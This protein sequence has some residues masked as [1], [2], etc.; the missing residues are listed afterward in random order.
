M[1]R[2]AGVLGFVVA[3][4]GCAGGDDD[5][6]GD[7]TPILDAVP[8]VPGVEIGNVDASKVED[9]VATD[10][11]TASDAPSADTA[12]V[13]ASALDAYAADTYAADTF[14][15]DTAKA[16]TYVADTYVADTYVADTAKA[17]TYVADTYVADTY[18]ADTFVADT[19]K[20]DTFVPDTYV[21]PW[22]HTISID[23]TNDF[24]AASE[25][26]ATTTSSF[27][28]YVTWDA[29]A[30]YVAYNGS[31]VASG[32][33][34]RWLFVYLDTDPGA[35]TGATSSEQYAT[36]RHSFASGFGAEHYYAWRADG[37]FPQQ[38]KYG[39]GAWTSVAG[40]VTAG[41]SGTYVEVKIPWA[42]V[43]SPAK[44][45]VSSFFLNE[46][47]GGEWTYAGLYPSAFTDGYSGAAAPK[48][49]GSYLKVDLASPAAP[50]DPANK[51]P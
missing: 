5:V 1:R 27:D 25:K 45:G 39:A 30:L 34:T 23:G 3:L 29:T 40:T 16:D 7:A 48:L 19:A 49:I 12:A 43:G 8:D 37:L 9:A 46:A 14:V 4:G 26:L 13:D 17:N 22:R 33:S 42:S 28:A 11:G 18:A 32:S 10:T 35:G 21:A 20:A 50:N 51:G 44:V 47:A 6:P 24:T 31:D 2:V 15:A 41:R 38:K 36:Q